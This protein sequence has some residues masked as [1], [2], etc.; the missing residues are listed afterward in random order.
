MT[1]Y[2]YMSK[3]FSSNNSTN[4]F[5]IVFGVAFSL[6]AL[7]LGYKAMSNG[8]EIRSKASTQRYGTTVFTDVPVNSFGFSAIERI[9]THGIT[10]GCSTNPLKFC[11][12][13]PITRGAAAVFMV[14]AM[15]G[16]D[17]VPELST[18]GIFA[19][20]DEN[21][22][23][24]G[25]IEQLYRDGVTSG[26]S[27]S[28]LKFCSEKALT[29][30]E[31]A[32]FFTVAIHGRGYTPPEATGTLFSDV[33]KNTFAAKFIE[34]LSRDGFTN[35]KYSDS[36][37]S[38]LNCENGPKSYCP[39][40]KA[41]RALMAV[42]IERLVDR[43]QVFSDVP[44]NYWAFSSI[45]RLYRNR[46]TSGCNQN[47]LSYCP[48]SPLTRG[49]AAVMI[50]RANK[51]SGY[52][53]AVESTPIFS[54]VPSNHPF[55]SFIEEL[56]RDGITSGCGNGNFC[57]DQVLTRGQA[58]VFIMRTRYG[59]DYSPASVGDVFLDVPKNAPLGGFIEKFYTQDG[60]TVGC[61]RS[62]L[63]FCPNEPTTRA[64]MA[65]FLDRTFKLE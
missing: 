52:T 19:D 24:R 50:V 64:A 35:I 2:S 7:A 4:V 43:P 29:R 3:K 25:Y 56:S 53:P 48:N 61:S 26:C 49:Q 59:K 21:D 31:L 28:P 10:S 11:P 9:F 51:G 16:K 17:Y 18:P 42:M 44:P 23:F 54:D 5:L 37:E 30:A 27:A 45:Q 13:E 63:R 41:S 46:I 60:L 6:I 14:R 47:P 32:V 22:S 38:S 39:Q 40:K 33:N 65:I 55:R 62:P 20:V 12:N 36:S 57:P 1:N 34:Q 58:T 8:T 15:H